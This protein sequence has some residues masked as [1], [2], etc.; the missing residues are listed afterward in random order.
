MT[1][2]NRQRLPFA[3]AFRA[4]AVRPR[5]VGGKEALV[6]GVVWS[7]S[8]GCREVVGAPVGSPGEPFPTLSAPCW[9]SGLGQARTRLFELQQ[10]RLGEEHA[11]PRRIEPGGGAGIPDEGDGAAHAEFLIQAA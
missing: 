9:G 6:V 7:Q 1:L 4:D 3:P 2:P 11:H 8:G 10:E 5:V